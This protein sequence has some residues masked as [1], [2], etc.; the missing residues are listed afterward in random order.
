[1]QRRGRY[2]DAMGKVGDSNISLVAAAGFIPN[3]P[4][5]FF[6][7]ISPP[8]LTLVSAPAEWGLVLPR[9]RL[10]S[11]ICLAAWIRR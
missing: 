9:S 3:R 7:E 2:A 5:V 11:R 10:E 1:V 6:S 8:L 4:A